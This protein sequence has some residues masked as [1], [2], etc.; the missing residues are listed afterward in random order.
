[1]SQ[2]HRSLH[3]FPEFTQRED[4]KRIL[5]VILLAKLSDDERIQLV[6]H[7][8]TA[9]PD[10]VI[11]QTWQPSSRILQYV[12]LQGA[13]ADAR[14][15]IYGLAILAYQVG[16]STFVVADNLTRRQLVE[17]SRVSERR[18]VSMVLVRVR[19]RTSADPRNKDIHV[20]VVAK[21]TAY[22]REDGAKL[23]E[24]HPTIEPDT[25]TGKYVSI[26][27]TQFENGF[28]LHD[29]DKPVFSVDSTVDLERG[30]FWDAVEELRAKTSLPVELSDNIISDVDRGNAR[31]MSLPSW[32]Q[33]TVSDLNIFALGPMQESQVRATQSAIQDS[34]HSLCKDIGNIRITARVIPWEHSQ[35]ASRRDMMN[36]WAQ[37]CEHVRNRV[38]YPVMNFL[39][40]R[41][42]NGNSPSFATAFWDN[43]RPT[44][45]RRTTLKYMIDNRQLNQKFTSEHRDF[46]NELVYKEDENN[47]ILDDPD[48]PFY[49]N[50][51]PWQPVDRM[52]NTISVFYLTN[53]LTKEEDDALR[54]E[55]ATP[56]DRKPHA[57]FEQDKLC[58]FIPWKSGKEGETDG[59]VED[60]WEI[61]WMVMTRS[62][63][64]DYSPIFFVDYQSGRDMKTIVAE[65]DHYFYDDRIPEDLKDV[66]NPW[67]KGLCYGRISG[68]NSHIVYANLSISNQGFDEIMESEL[69]DDGLAEEHEVH[70]VLH[71]FPR[72]GFPAERY[73]ENSEDEE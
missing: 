20:D 39:I 21:R 45:V 9:F 31:V 37:Y 12:A 10:N 30:R 57:D 32:V 72:P 29:P 28:F 54:S 17:E 38:H 65:F 50:L 61:F 1:M 40:E 13:H 19:P 34:L 68:R 44:V 35:F 18:L 7:Y 56:W 15:N 69:Y 8:E 59:T 41:F 71:K 33:Q 49:A 51:P 70:E 52:A 48:Q 66:P 47:E 3:G 64:D 25:L 62:V 16:W 43:G 36:L 5:L 6:R 55:I 60:M 42:E 11:I 58:C 2:V 26:S 4:G 73:M 23:L 63:R 14:A 67:I 22:G 27:G 53:K 24:I 46:L